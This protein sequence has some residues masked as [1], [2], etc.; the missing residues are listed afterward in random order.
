MDLEEFYA[1]YYFILTTMF[2][3][4]TEKERETVAV[5]T[6]TAYMMY[7]KTLH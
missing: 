4:F 1:S 5:L 3:P 2:C 6:R 7:A